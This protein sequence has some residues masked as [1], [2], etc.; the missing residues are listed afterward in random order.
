MP[1]RP[2]RLLLP[3]RRFFP[4]LVRSVVV[5]LGSRPPK[6]VKCGRIDANVWA[7]IPRTRVSSPRLSSGVSGGA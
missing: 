3:A 6:S 2:M 7:V 1:I 5:E 4:G